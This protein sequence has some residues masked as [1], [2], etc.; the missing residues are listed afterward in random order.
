MR[1]VRQITRRGRSRPYL[2]LQYGAARR[3]NA[4]FEKAQGDRQSEFFQ[5]PVYRFNVDIEVVHQ[6]LC[7]LEN[8]KPFG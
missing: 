1:G 8:G 6:I 3:S 7:T 5:Q 2:T 4:P